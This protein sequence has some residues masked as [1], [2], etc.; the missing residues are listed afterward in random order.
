M[1]K[2]RAKTEGEVKTERSQREKR[3]SAAVSPLGHGEA[4]WS[5]QS[6]CQAA[7]LLKT[8]RREFRLSGLLKL[9]SSSCHWGNSSCGSAPLYPP[10]KVLRLVEAHPFIPSL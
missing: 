5:A 9:A 3:A 8:A 1:K 10:W 7:E 6:S 2:T 4:D